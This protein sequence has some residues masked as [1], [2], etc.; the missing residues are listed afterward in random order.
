MKTIKKEEYARLI[1]ALYDLEDLLGCI[2]VK[3]FSLSREKHDLEIDTDA[4]HIDTDLLYSFCT[5]IE[6]IHDV[7]FGRTITPNP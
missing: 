4:E 6:H 3:Q 7:K 1:K 2:G 5:D